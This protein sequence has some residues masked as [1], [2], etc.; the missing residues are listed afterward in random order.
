[1]YCHPPLFLEQMIVYYRLSLVLV[2]FVTLLF[3]LNRDRVTLHIGI[4]LF[5]MCGEEEGPRWWRNRMGRPLSVLQIHQKNNRTQS[6]L[7]IAS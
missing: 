3:F 5:K 4:T 2:K 6:K 1:M 7:L